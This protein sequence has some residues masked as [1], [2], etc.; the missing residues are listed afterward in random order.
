MCQPAEFAQATKP[1]GERAADLY[2]DHAD[3]TWYFGFAIFKPPF[4][5]VN[6]RR[7][8]ASAVDLTA[9]SV[10]GLNGIYP[11]QPR[12]LREGFPCG[13]NEQWQ[14]AFDPEAAKALLAESS[15]GGPE[16]L[17]PITI[18][19][20]EQGGATALGTWGRV[21]TIIQ[22]QLQQNLGV[23]VELVRQV[24]NSVPEQVEYINSVEGGAIFRLSFGYPVQDPS[25]LGTVVGTGSSANITGYSNPEI[26]ALI[27]EANAETDEEERCA[28]YTQID[29]TVSEDAIFLA[30]FRGTSTWFFK[31]KVRGMKVVL[32]RIWNS[33]HEM[34]IA[35]EG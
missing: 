15:Y 20:S 11:P 14:P 6:V 22:Q 35:G 16:A 32:G 30:A 19:I 31:P 26:D 27:A 18:V 29:Q 5:D 34:Y 1:D 24:F 21:A 17:P 8:F 23:N 7:A 10:A 12:I 4:E 3:A 33:I 2:W 28:L 25:N 13:G 9:L